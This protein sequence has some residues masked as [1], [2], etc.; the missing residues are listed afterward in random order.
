[1][2]I[3]FYGNDR[4]HVLMAVDAVQHSCIFRGWSQK[5]M[6]SLAQDDEYDREVVTISHSH[7]S[8]AAELVSAFILGYI[9]RSDE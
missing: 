4:E 9:A 7:D 5:P 8:Y 3:H 1:M 6:I 2:D